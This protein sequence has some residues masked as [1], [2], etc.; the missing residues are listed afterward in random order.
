MK[1][2]LTIGHSYVAAANRALAHHMALEGRGEWSVTAV[3]P[4]QF[5]GDLR[6]IPVEPIPGEASA[7]TSVPVRLDRV[8]H[9]MWYGGNTRELIAGDWDVIHCWEEPYVLAAAQIARAMRH[10][11]RLVV[12][13]FQNIAK[14]YPWPL[15]AFE[16]YTM[17]RASGWVAFGE[18]IHAALGQRDGYRATQSRVIPPGVDLERFRP[19]PNAA[20]VLRRR[21]GWSDDTAVVGFLGRFVESKGLRLLLEA[22]ESSRSPWHALLVGGG[23]LEGE[24]HAFAG[25]HP[26]RVHVQT[27]ISHGDVPQWLNVMTMIC[28]PSQTTG[29]WRE[30]FG[31]MLIEAMA[32]GVPVIAS[33]SGEIPAV[34]GSAGTIVGEA[35]TAAWTA[36]IDRLAA[37][38]A[39]RRQ[40]R[41]RGLARVRSHFAWPIVARAHLAFF[42]DVLRERAA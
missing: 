2:L 33:D 17:E 4:S 31:R 35:D 22:L 3:A 40:Q 39:L 42:D 15:S 16:H 8:P 7:L 30:Q 29:R 21:L 41:E 1:R 36:A 34:I 37:D 26:G 11:A 25:R 38:E 32:C 28:A 23:P 18:T 13:T 24:L 14:R 19:D 6:S 20:R 9:L 10:P 5:R 27:G 12:A